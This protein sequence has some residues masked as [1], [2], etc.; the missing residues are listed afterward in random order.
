MF[1]KP[2]QI[3]V[4]IVFLVREIPPTFLNPDFLIYN[5]I[6]P[7]DWV[8]SLP[9]ITTSSHSQVSYSSGLQVTAGPI[10]VQGG[11]IATKIMFRQE[12][13]G[14]NLAD[15][16]IVT[17]AGVLA[18]L[19]DPSVFIAIGL[20]S[21]IFFETS[22]QE[23]TRRY[24]REQF[25]QNSKWGL[26][27]SQPI[28]GEVQLIYETAHVQTRIKIDQYTLR[29]GETTS[30]GLGVDS[31]LHYDLSNRNTTEEINLIVASSFDLISKHELSVANR[32]RG[33][34]C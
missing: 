20:N 18:R 12:L 23:S 33:G 15:T 27:E 3:D 29:R 19:I 6:V 10:Q 11:E 25:L 9:P 1:E 34:E 16:T 2:I 5:E 13:V 22:N 28:I 26:D 32:I 30:E 7:E 14:K 24:L 8:P 17:N 21:R 31:N 4:S